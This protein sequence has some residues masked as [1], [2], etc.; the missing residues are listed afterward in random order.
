MTQSIISYFSSLRDQFFNSVSCRYHQ[1]ITLIKTKMNFMHASMKSKAW[2]YRNVVVLKT[3]PYLDWFRNQF[4]NS[5]SSRYYNS[6]AA[7]KN[8]INSMHFND[9]KTLAWKHKYIVVLTVPPFLGWLILKAFKSPPDADK[10]PHKNQPSQTS[11]DQTNKTGSIPLPRKQDCST[12]YPIVGKEA[13]AFAE[14]QLK[15][16][17]IPEDCDFWWFHLGKTTL[18]PEKLKK[19]V[20]LL[21]LNFTELRNYI[22]PYYRQKG[23]TGEI[24]DPWIDEDVKNA[25][26][27]CVQIAYAISIQ[28]F[29]NLIKES[30]PQTYLTNL[31][32]NHSYYR[33]TFFYLPLYYEL[34]RREYNY[35][36]DTDYNN[37]VVLG[38][39]PKTIRLKHQSLFYKNGTIQNRWNT[40]YNHYCDVVHNYIKK[41]VLQ[42]YHEYDIPYFF[43]A[44]VK[45]T[46]ESYRFNEPIQPAAFF[47]E[48]PP[49][50]SSLRPGVSQSSPTS[51]IKTGK[52][53]PSKNSFAQ[54]RTSL[55]FAELSIDLEQN[56]SSPQTVALTFCI[57]TSASME[58]EDPNQSRINF[59]KKAFKKIFK[60]A[61]EMTQQCANFN[62]LMQIY[63]FDDNTFKFRKDR[64]LINK[65]TKEGFNKI[66][67]DVDNFLTC[68]VGNKITQALFQ[69][70]T[71]IGKESKP[72]PEESQFLILLTD[73]E[74]A[75]EEIP[76]YALS[77]LKQRFDS[78]AVQFYLIGI[79]GH[80]SKQ[81]RK[82]ANSFSSESFE[83][84]Y[85]DASKNSKSIQNSL[86]N[87]YNESQIIFKNFT[88]K[89]NE[90]VDVNALTVLDFNKENCKPK[91]YSNFYEYN[92]GSL[93]ATTTPKAYFKFTPEKVS[94]TFDL[95]N[96]QFSLEYYDQRQRK[97][98]RSQFNWQYSSTFEPNIYSQYSNRSLKNSSNVTQTQVTIKGA[99]AAQKN[100][101]TSTKLVPEVKILTALNRAKINIFIPTDPYPELKI[102]LMFCIDISASMKEKGRLDAVQDGLILIL[103]EAKKKVEIPKSKTRIFFKVWGCHTFDLK[104]EILG[105]TEIT[106][107]TDIA[108]LEKKIKA[109][110]LGNGT[111]IIGG[112]KEALGSLVKEPQSLQTTSYKII[113]LTDG[114]DKISGSDSENLKASSQMLEKFN[115]VQL[116]TIGIGD[117]HNKEILNKIIAECKNSEYFDATEGGKAISDKIKAIFNKSLSTTTKIKLT[118]PN[119]PPN[120]WRIN[121]QTPK[122][123]E[124]N[125]GNLEEGSKLDKIIEVDLSQINCPLDLSKIFFNL[126]FEEFNGS[127]QD[128]VV[129]WSPNSKIEPSLFKQN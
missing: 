90:P 120:S 5:V 104:Q 24:G 82:I 121:Q 127:S 97:K 7:I 32:N 128:V 81:L 92:L 21:E 107:S 9:V 105:S 67:A 47:Y 86:E 96:F 14:E 64:I 53:F 94:K 126:N 113:L 15:T 112:L 93:K 111:D 62:I 48:K 17:S 110:E 49:L 56:P 10:K 11:V 83:R 33:I 99:P 26:N 77:D 76:S 63:K 36:H 20:Y 30:K 122:N 72:H 44:T 70:I 31:T 109:I 51:S 54:L 37:A 98:F 57:D 69:T 19:L 55:N 4:F 16:L 125:L 23:V 75:D 102:F 3:S 38:P 6:I 1:S 18:L 39:A 66:L 65:I 114:E 61:Y 117:G 40:L 79:E 25:A 78:A 80:D 2:D 116:F 68:G 59:V 34:T 100:Q 8:Q 12:D 123:G 108:Q 29:E 85:I 103:N 88:L 74:Y 13:L 50:T 22:T 87:V 27:K 115:D 35:Y 41:N 45:D 42:N 106:K 28:A 73:G 129:P 58:N 95:S 101:P 91:K 52:V 71:D 118:I 46:D 124:C 43:N 60:D 84:V 89:L 119:L